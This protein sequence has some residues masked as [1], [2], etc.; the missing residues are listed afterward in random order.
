VVKFGAQGIFPTGGGVDWCNASNAIHVPKNNEIAK[1]G[2]FF[3]FINGF[4]GVFQFGMEVY[5]QYVE[6]GSILEEG[7]EDIVISFN[8]VLGNNRDGFVKYNKR[9]TTTGRV[10]MFR[11]EFLHV[12]RE[13]EVVCLGEAKNREAKSICLLE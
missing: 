1:G 7:S 9:S 2:E 8:N 13:L 10:F 3:G 6:E 5:H 4:F 11:G 12:C